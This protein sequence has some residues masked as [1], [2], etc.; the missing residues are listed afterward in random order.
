M[1]KAQ[2]LLA[3][4]WMMTYFSFALKEAIVMIDECTMAT[5]SHAELIVPAPVF[6]NRA[7]WW[8]VSQFPVIT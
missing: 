5:C 3:F 4:A 6:K 7:H 1:F 8:K 2:Q